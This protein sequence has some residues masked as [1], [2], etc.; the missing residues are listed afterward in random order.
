[1]SDSRATTSSPYR[2]DSPYAWRRMLGS[3]ALMTTGSSGMYVIMV[4]MPALQAEF[5][6]DR[7]GA[8]LPFTLIMLGFGFGGI[9]MGKVADRRGVFFSTI[10]GTL[11]LVAGYL[12]AGFA[13]SYM[14]FVIIHG[15][16]V[17]TGISATFVPILMDVSHWFHRRRGVAVAIAA[18]GNYF[19]GAIWPPIAQQM[20]AASGWRSTYLAIG[21]LCLVV[22]LP[23][24]FILRRQ[25]EAEDQREE[26]P[27]NAYIPSSELGLTPAALTNLLFIAGVGCCV[28]MAMPQVHV[29]SMC[30]DFGFGAARGAEMLSLM[31]T[32]GIVSRFTFGAIADRIGGLRTLMI[33]SALQCLALTF[34]LPAQG[35]MSMYAVSAIFGLFQ[36]GIVPCYALIIRQFFPPAEAGQRTGIVVLGTVLGM[37]FGGWASGEIFD[38]TGSYSIA[39]IHGIG[40]NLLN[41]LIAGFL[42][43]RWRAGGLVAAAA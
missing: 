29:V 43:R 25:R 39:F 6:I 2:I 21:V 19:A 37:A 4:T 11:I 34:F 13:N 27:Q 40:W 35:L 30:V 22:M 42:I 7:G 26:A 16:L 33:S 41:L 1:M 31:L 14:G 17:G 38:W 18:S 3:L 28:A 10:V 23:L 36:G 8:S 9:V 15:L 20:I 24:S 5:G 32:C 12:W